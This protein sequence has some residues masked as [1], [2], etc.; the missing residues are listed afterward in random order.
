MAPL[1][2]VSGLAA[3]K[4]EAE[5][6]IRHRQQALE[7]AHHHP[8]GVQV[9][10]ENVEGGGYRLTVQG[11]RGHEIECLLQGDNG[12]SDSFEG[13]GEAHSVTLRAT[14]G[15]EYLQVTDRTTGRKDFFKIDSR[16]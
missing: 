6:R 15:V 5:Q 3:M 12:F 8:Q 1:H 4:S 16:Q 11:E 10:K 14:R 13:E 2:Y 7:E 9:L